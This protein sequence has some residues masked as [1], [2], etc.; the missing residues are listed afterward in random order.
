MMAWGRLEGCAKSQSKAKADGTLAGSQDRREVVASAAVLQSWDRRTPGRQISR[1][2]ECDA[3]GTAGR[4]KTELGRAPWWIG[5][6][7]RVSCRSPVGPACTAAGGRALAV[8][9]PAARHG[10]RCAPLRVSVPC[11]TEHRPP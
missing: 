5:P 2:G 6:S 11:A 10:P 1:K 7:G 4:S 3:D 8:P 9:H